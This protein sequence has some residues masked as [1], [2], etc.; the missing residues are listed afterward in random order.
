MYLYNYLQNI[1]VIF[2]Y[3][4][5]LFLNLCKIIKTLIIKIN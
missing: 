5:K 1:K 3:N 4:N 2:V